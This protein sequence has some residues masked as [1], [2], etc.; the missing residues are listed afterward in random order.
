MFLIFPVSAIIQGNKNINGDG[1]KRLS[2][3]QEL[4][5]VKIKEI[6]PISELSD[7]AVK[8]RFINSDIC[9]LLRKEI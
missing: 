3:M 2:L 8:N 5:L 7:K 1:G 6:K 9:R 4:Q